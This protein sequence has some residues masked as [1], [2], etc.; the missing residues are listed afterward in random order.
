MGWDG[1][2]S[3]RDDTRIEHEVFPRTGRVVEPNEAYE[4]RVRRLALFAQD[5]WNLTPRWSMY[6]GLRWE[7][8]DTTSEGNTFATVSRRSSVWRWGFAM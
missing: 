7:G 8:I 1:G 5:E 6:A 2:T 3:L 4:A